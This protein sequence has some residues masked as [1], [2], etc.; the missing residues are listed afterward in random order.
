MIDGVPSPSHQIWMRALCRALGTEG[1]NVTVLSIPSLAKD[2]HKNVH[3]HFMPELWAWMQNDMDMDMMDLANVSPYMQL[4]GFVP[5]YEPMDQVALNSTGFR[6]LLDYPKNFKFDLMIYDYLSSY[7]LVSLKEYF[8]NPPLIAVSPYPG[9][10]MTNLMTKGPEYFSFIPHMMKDEVRNCFWDRLNNFVL[11]SVYAFLEEYYILP[12]ATKSVRK[13]L[14]EQKQT[15]A[16]V[17]LSSTIQMANYHPAIDAVHPIMP[18]VIPVG[19]LQIAQPK[20]LPADLEEIYSKKSKGNILFSLGSN[21]K[22]EDLGI[23]RLNEITGALA[24]LSDYNFIWKIDLKGLDLKIPKN[25]YI[26]KWLPQNDMLADNRTVLF[27]SHAGGLSTQECTWFGVP[28]LALPVM[29]DQFP[30]S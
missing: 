29:F 20:P 10:G 9:I 3:Y 28:M 30:V 7:A 25:V 6:A 2:S 26:R 11:T 21:A 19:G 27:I 5:M 1:Y 18:S 23:D 4:V 14:P 24:E 15:I 17:L 16:E 13:V 8:N 12:V 22:S